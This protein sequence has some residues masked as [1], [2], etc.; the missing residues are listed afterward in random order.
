MCGL[1]APISN[2]YPVVCCESEAGL[3]LAQKSLW[4]NF[5]ESAIREC[6]ISLMMMRLHEVVCVVVPNLT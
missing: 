3:H 1:R 4:C 2:L 6:I 5:K